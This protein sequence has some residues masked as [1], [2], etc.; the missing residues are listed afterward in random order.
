MKLTELEIEEGFV[1]D[2]VATE[3]E[4]RQ[5]II[6]MGFT[7]GAKGWI[8]R[9]APLGDPIEVHIMDYEIS[10]RNSEAKGIEVSKSEVEIKKDRILKSSDTK[11]EKL[12]LDSNL[13]ENREDIYKKI[14]VPS[15]NTKL[16]VAIAGNPNCGK[17]TI[18]NALT[19][20]NYKVANYPGVTVERREKDIVYN[21]YTYDLIDLPG[22]YSLSAYSQDEV[23]ACDVLLNEKPDFII[24]V[25]DATNLERNLYL[26]LQ[27]I[28]LG[29]PIVCVLNMYEFAEKNGVKINEKI[30][31]DILRLP[32]IKVYGNKYESVLLILDKIEYMY[33]SGNKLNKDAAMRYGETVEK[34]IKTITDNMQ[35]DLSDLHKRWLAIKTF[36]KDERAI[37]SIRREC[38]N[39]GEVIETVNKEI[40]KLESSENAK[41]DSIMADK[42]YSYIRGALQE[43]VKKDNI[44]AFNFTEAA[45]VVFLNKWLGIPIFLVVLWLIFKV[46]FTLGAYPQE[47]IDMGISALSDFVGG[48]LEGS[49]LIQSLVVDGIIGGVGAVLSFFPLVLILF[50]GISFL[51]DCGYMAR[52]A[53]LM[54]KV[55]HRLGLHGQSF[56]PL[57]L[58]FGCSI[59][60]TMAARTLR[61][62]KDRIVT[63]LITTFM[64]CGARVPVYLMFT[65]AFFSPK[66][67]PTIMF[68]IYIIGVITAFIIAFILRKALFKGEET[69]FVME[70]PPYR[71][72]RAKAVLRHMFDRGWM[73]IK[74]AGTY[75]FAASVIIWALMTFPQYEPNEQEEVSLREQAIAIASE[76]ELDIE[77]EEIINTEYDKVLSSEGLRRSYAGQIGRFIEPIIKPLGFDWRIGIALVAGGAAKEVLVST[78]AQIV[79]VDEEDEAS[80]TELLQN[81]PVFNPIVAY[82]LLLFVLLYFPCFAAIGVM[83]AEIGNKWIPFIVVYTL[84]VAWIVSFVFY[85]ISGRIAGII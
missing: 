59:P 20:A 80:L 76:Q 6:E 23:V 24:D 10:L 17:T 44:R 46:T 8:V 14:K 83:G 41:S 27:L 47:W 50:V 77:D 13:I 69:P 66:I 75:V 1:V 21:G 28:E 45:D 35:G 60:A 11:K 48:L 16:K 74:K 49:P 54:D 84:A 19:G 42:R 40:I 61:N 85:Q 37:H 22:V 12:E 18:F 65:A 4:I 56:I 30:L 78:I 70:L 72:P 7:P 58:G 55:M 71:A 3:G 43:A 53:F 32:F 81:D 5:R 82:S 26:T 64:S 15:N 36:E 52:A 68:S 51:E 39:G 73:Y 79:R 38:S 29:I 62:K 25:I 34:S 57:F 33:K 9:K 31:T 63:V 67:A 2:K